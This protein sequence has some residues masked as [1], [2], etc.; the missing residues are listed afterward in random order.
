MEARTYLA[1]LAALRSYE[2]KLRLMADMTAEENRC[3]ELFAKQRNSWKV[4]GLEDP[5]LS[6]VCVHREDAKFSRTQ[7]QVGR[8][9]T[10]MLPPTGDAPPR[11]ARRHAA[12]PSFLSLQFC[13]GAGGGGRSH[14]VTSPSRLPGAVSR[15]SR[16]P[17]GFSLGRRPQA[18]RRSG[19]RLPPR[20]HPQPAGRVL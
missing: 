14:S 12:Q 10:H 3:R 11:P 15:G 5:Y 4:E 1:R 2:E 17:Q 18:R 6:L 19:N 16:H 20:L 9:S 7:E 13:A 8:A